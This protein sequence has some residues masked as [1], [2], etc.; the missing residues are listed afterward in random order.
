MGAAVL[1]AA[2]SLIPA[3][4]PAHAGTPRVT[5]EKFGSAPDGTPVQRYTLTSAAGMRVRILTFGGIVQSIDAPDRHGHLA[6]VALGYKSVADYVKDQA[7]QATYFGALI[8]RYGNRIAKGTFKL[9]GKTYHIP[10]N[11]N[12]NAL[13]GGTVG[14]N[15]KVWKATPIT[16]GGTV[17]VRLRYVSPDGEMGFPG[18]LTTT[19]EY[20][21]GRGNALRIHYGA[22][23]DKPTVV[24]LTNHTYFNLGG[25]GT[26]TIYGH[27]LT[28]D[29][30]RYTPTDKTQIPTGA[31][32]KVAGTPMDFT[33]PYPIGARIRD[34]FP[35][36]IIGQGY[37]H[38]WVLDRNGPTA[39]GGL[40][41]AARVV[42]PNSGRVLTTYTTQPGVQF[43]SGNFLDGTEIGISGH[44]YRQGDGFALETQHFPDSPNHPNFPST[45]L[46]PGQRYDQTTV[47]AFST[48]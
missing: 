15:L 17:G 21:L 23:T 14:F 38:N 5:V 37:D 30:S 4:A 20:T 8:G 46:R 3:T 10:V 9:D 13:H 29:G 33:R 36:L 22:T 48:T 6:D 27:R 25:E 12:G 7:N 44:A 18:R 41:Q 2:A 40:H 26:G 47:Y 43:Y 45:V 28:I 34:D 24:N 39:Y 16:S 31:I 11:N 1:L 42:E 32:D 19:V 35:Q